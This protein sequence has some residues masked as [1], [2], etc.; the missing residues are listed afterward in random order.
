MHAFFYHLYTHLYNWLIKVL[1]GMTAGLGPRLKIH[2]I[3]RDPGVDEVLRFS[4]SW[5]Y[6]LI[7]NICHF[8][9]NFSYLFITFYVY[10]FFCFAYISNR[11]VFVRFFLLLCSV[12]FSYIKCFTS[13]ILSSEKN[14]NYFIFTNI[15]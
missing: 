7:V 5:P 2:R 1:S 3:R 10:I 14:L 9:S 8:L 12:L 4:F 6:L 11:A 13:K 15:F